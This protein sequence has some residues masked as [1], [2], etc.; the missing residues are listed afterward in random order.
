[1]VKS[2]KVIVVAGARPNFMKVAPILHCIARHNK[3]AV[4]G[5]PQ[6]V[7]FLVL[8]VF[9]RARHSRAGCEP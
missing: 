6:I 9:R 3:K 1:M 4:N 2:I 7:P 8:G 5:T